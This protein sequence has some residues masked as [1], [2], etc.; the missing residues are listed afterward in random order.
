MTSIGLQW[1]ED[2]A[3]MK[4]TLDR[5][6]CE[7]LNRL[8]ICNVSHS[9]QDAGKPGNEFFAG[10]HFNPNVT[11]WEQATAFITWNSRISF[12]LSQG[13]F[14]GDVCYYYG[15][16]VPNQVPMKHVNE[17]L[18][19]G[20][21][22]DVCNTEVILERMTVRDG[23]IC[24]PDGMSYQALVLP[25]HKGITPAVMKKLKKMKKAGATVIDPLADPPVRE[26]LQTKGILPDFTYRSAKPDA[27]IDYIHRTTEDAEIYYVANRNE[28]PEYLQLSFRVEGKTPE[29]WRPETGEIID[30]PIYNSTGGQT[31]LPLFF[32]PFGSVFVVFRKPA[33]THYE[34]IALNGKNLFPELPQ[35]TFDIQPFI[36]Q[37]DGNP[38][39]MLAGAYTL[40]SSDGKTRTF[41]AIMENMP[42]TS[43]WDVSFDPVWGGPEKVRFD[44]LVLWNE[45]TDPGI[46]YYSGTAGYNTTV[47][48]EAGQYQHK[49]VYLDLGEMYNIAEVHINGQP[50]GV[51]WQPPFSH[52]ITDLLKDGENRIELKIVN[53]WPNRL[54][55]DQFLS[56]EKRFTK[57]NIK[58]FTKEHPLRPSGLAGP[59]NIRI[60][61]CN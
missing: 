8:V 4:P 53:L 33:A 3:Y 61:S 51:W 16:N 17:D 38:V 57:S 11:W 55:G 9:P 21:D 30:W 23:R 25:K 40:K 49:R 37:K 26:A 59:V 45:H 58:K 32:E 1:E 56:E 36:L 52:D 2:F 6:Y 24:L 35:D 44:K 27:L 41:D 28:R 43:A 34:S 54:I 47:R 14:V 20:Y 19:E 42:V 12:M 60:Y 7:G 18:G 46:R 31:L 50:A 5:A 29:L 13:L 39:F 15:D 48:L 22:Y 10:T